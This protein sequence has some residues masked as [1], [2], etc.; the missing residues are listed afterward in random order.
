MMQLLADVGPL[1]YDLAGGTPYR[2]A[3]STMVGD[4]V[5]QRAWSQTN[6]EDAGRAHEDNL[7]PVGRERGLGAAD[8]A[9]GVRAVSLRDIDRH[10]S[11]FTTLEGEHVARRGEARCFIGSI[12]CE[13]E[14]IAGGRID[15]PDAGLGSV[16]SRVGDHAVPAWKRRDGGSRRKP[17]ENTDE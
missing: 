9:R 2:P 6:E 15:R 8:E 1:E 12:G 17:G 10:D 11:M 5:C 13:A 14:L 7:A 3:I 4:L 16:R